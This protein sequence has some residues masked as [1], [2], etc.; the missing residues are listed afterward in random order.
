MNAAALANLSDDE[1]RRLEGAAREFYKR[2]LRLCWDTGC[3]VQMAL[4]ACEDADKSPT[5]PSSHTA[6]F[7]SVQ[8][9][10]PIEVSL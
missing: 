3:S 6:A 7:E 5:V 4:R 10:L 8:A 9:S 2:V 1:A